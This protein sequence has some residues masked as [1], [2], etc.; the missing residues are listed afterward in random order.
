M[1]KHIPLGLWKTIVK[2]FLLLRRRG[3]NPSDLREVLPELA[4]INRRRG[5]FNQQQGHDY[6]DEEEGDDAEQEEFWADDIHGQEEIKRTQSAPSRQQS[7]QYQQQHRRVEEY[8]GEDSSDVG[9]PTTA[10]QQRQQPSP[11]FQQ[12]TVANNRASSA[13][14]STINKHSRRPHGRGK[15][16]TVP[17]PHERR[18]REYYNRLRNVPSRLSGIIQ[19]D[20]GKFIRNR[21]QTDNAA[22]SSL[23]RRRVDTLLNTSPALGF[24][25]PNYYLQPDANRKLNSTQRRRYQDL[26]S[27][28]AALEI[29][30]AF[31]RG[32]VGKELM[33][34]SE[35]DGTEYL[36]AEEEI[37]DLSP[38][39]AQRRAAA[40]LGTII[41]LF[42]FAF[43]LQCS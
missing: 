11:K 19:Q 22:M 39:E 10:Q 24:R 30:D 21:Q 41:A 15:G 7:Q 26:D 40:M 34:T 18:S 43:A 42:S 23:A 1:E 27:G 17:P 33:S 38:L 32:S 2:N 3:I 8:Y 6:D 37:D 13:Q 16:N 12:S 29:A 14:S 4:E 28:T 9:G 25:D 35:G 31:L 36:L 20:R 5:L